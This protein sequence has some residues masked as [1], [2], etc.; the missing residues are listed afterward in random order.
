MGITNIHV[1]INEDT[2]STLIQEAQA[3]LEQKLVD[4]HRMGKHPYGS[5]RRDCPLCQRH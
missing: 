4:D 1:L 3:A 2:G 5:M